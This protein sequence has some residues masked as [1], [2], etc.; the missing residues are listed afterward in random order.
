MTALKRGILAAGLHQ[1]LS[2]TGPYIVFAP[3]G[4]AFGKLEAGTF[5]NLLKPE[6]SVMLTEMLNHLIVAVKI[7]FKEL[8]DGDKLKSLNGKELSVK[9]AN[10][11]IS[12]DGDTIQNRDMQTSNGIIHFWI[13]Y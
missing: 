3:S 7:N 13:P 10:A 1:I 8:K 9:V 6:N 2:G 4:L 12:V 11:K 5:E